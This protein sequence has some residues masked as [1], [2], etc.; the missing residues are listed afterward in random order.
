MGVRNDFCID[1]KW[2]F[3]DTFDDS[4]I[5]GDYSSFDVLNVRIPHT[6]KELPFH[7]FDEHEY[8]MVSAYVRDLEVPK[9]WLMMPACM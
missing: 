2:G 7:Y 5:S 8:Q 3:I 1:D 9:E 6:V 4:L